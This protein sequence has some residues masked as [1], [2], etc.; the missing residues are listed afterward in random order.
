MAMSHEEDL[1]FALSPGGKLS[2]LAVK[3]SFLESPYTLPQ[4]LGHGDQ[5]IGGG[6]RFAQIE[7]NVADRS[8]R[9]V[10]GDEKFYPDGVVVE[11]GRS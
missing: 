4:R 3:K 2:R 8:A 1:A 11:I 7:F 10:V 5:T 9:I 6:K